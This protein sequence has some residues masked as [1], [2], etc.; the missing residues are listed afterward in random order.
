MLFCFLCPREEGQGRNIFHTIIW[1]RYQK[2]KPCSS[3][4]TWHSWTIYMRAGPNQIKTPLRHSGWL[5]PEINLWHIQN[6]RKAPLSSIEYLDKPP[7]PAPQ[8]T[9]L[10]RNQI[11]TSLSKVK[12]QGVHWT[13]VQCR[14]TLALLKAMD[15][16]LLFVGSSTKM[17]E[18]KRT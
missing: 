4:V 11:I 16:S 17:K 9:M 7:Q 18:T 2:T 5:P 6:S 12:I 15:R 8:T 10:L 3:R 1:E 13:I 14:T